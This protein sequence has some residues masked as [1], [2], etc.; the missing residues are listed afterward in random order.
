MYRFHIPDPVYFMKSISATSEHGHDNLLS[1]DYSS[2]AYWYQDEPHLPF[3]AFPPV[4][5]RLDRE[6]T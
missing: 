4:D 3:P 2:T 5:A 6:E 1:N